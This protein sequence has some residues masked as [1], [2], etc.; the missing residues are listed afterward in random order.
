MFGVIRKIPT[1][2]PHC[3]FV[4]NEPRALLSTFC[5]GCGDHYSTAAAP[6]NSAAI[7]LAIPNTPPDRRRSV[8]CTSCGESHFV[9]A[10]LASSRCPT[11][12]SE[13]DLTDVHITTHFTRPVDTRGSIH[14]TPSGY[15]NSP[16]TR[17]ASAR[18]E[19]RF[20]GRIDCVGTLRI[21]GEGIC[22]AHIETHTLIID[23]GSDFRFAFPIRAEE[24]LIRGH[25]EADIF[26]PGTIRVGR[27]GLL[28]GDV[29]T[30]SLIVD[31]GGAYEGSVE[32]AT[33]IIDNYPRAG[34][35]PPPELKVLPAWHSLFAHG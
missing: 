14:V 19:G 1:T 33:T 24:V 8:D 23:R 3:G 35:I 34:T 21:R 30:R 25:V 12:G 11:C 20:A 31:K 15:L 6:P 4:Q 16:H 22:R 29:H 5:R 32:V 10:H 13:T 2:C 27:Y 18:I 26:C 7:P 28:D 17:C 9:S